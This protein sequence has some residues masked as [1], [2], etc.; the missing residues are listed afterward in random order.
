MK[1]SYSTSPRRSPPSKRASSTSTTRGFSSSRGKGAANRV[2]KLAVRQ[3]DLRLAMLQY[4]RDRGGVEPHVDRVQH[5]AHH[6][7]AEMGLD[8]RGHVRQHRRNRVAFLQAAALQRAGEASATLV[9][10][11]PAPPDL[12]VNDGRAI[13]VDGR[14]A[15]DEGQRRKRLEIGRIPVESGFER[16]DH[17]ASPFACLARIRRTANGCPE[18]RRAPGRVPR[19]RR[20]FRVMS[21]RRTASVPA[22]SR[23]AERS[24]SRVRAFPSR[25]TEN[26]RPAR[27]GSRQDDRAHPERRL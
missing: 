7:D 9:G 16:I 24:K 19:I 27:R 25:S 17:G 10:F 13:G 21:A 1:S 12:A 18:K 23:S 15:L 14:R 4:E 26:R 8:H 22:T 6:G 3:Q 5:A 20:R 11:A 2:R